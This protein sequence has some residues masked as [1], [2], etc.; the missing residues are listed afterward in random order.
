[1]HIGSECLKHADVALLWLGHGVSVS[2]PGSHSQ[3]V[4]HNPI[5]RGHL[6]PSEI[7]D[8]YIKIHNSSKVTY[9]NEN[10]FVDGII[11]T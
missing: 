7:S 9:N 8:I 1:M 10:N 4:G 5:H 3:P 6:R 2:L 11:T